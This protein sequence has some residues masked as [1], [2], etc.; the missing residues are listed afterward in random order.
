M[1]SKSWFIKCKAST[2]FLWG[3]VP[4]FLGLCQFLRVNSFVTKF[5]VVVKT[6]CAEPNLCFYNSF[7]V[8]IL[9]EAWL[10]RLISS[11]M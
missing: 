7:I 4:L 2:W 3:M 9:G 11:Q 5:N 6:K 1:T 8:A 10:D